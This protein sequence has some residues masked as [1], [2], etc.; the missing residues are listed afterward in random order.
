MEDKKQYKTPT[1]V[2]YGK[3][4]DLTAGGTGT[5]NEGEPGSG[6]GGKALDI[7]KP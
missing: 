1:L 4:K 6:S 3:L 5:L 2:V 7:P